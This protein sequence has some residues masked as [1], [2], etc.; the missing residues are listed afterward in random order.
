MASK[1]GQINRGS[2]FGEALY[3]FAESLHVKTIV[4]VGTFNGCGSTRCILDGIAARKP[5]HPAF[6][7]IELYPNMYAEAKE[8]LKDHLD[9][10]TLLQGRLVDRDAANWFDHSTLDF[11]KDKHARL[12]YARIWN[13]YLPNHVFYR[14]C[15]K[16]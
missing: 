4:E 9:R 3:A 13:Y 14:S 15:L 8:N 11:T 10:V 2:A 6:F 12:W 1:S 7:S 16:L 5:P